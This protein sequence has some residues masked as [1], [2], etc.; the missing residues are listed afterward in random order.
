MDEAEYVA[1]LVALQDKRWKQILRV[2]RP[3]QMNILWHCTGPTLDVGCGIGR[4]LKVLPQGSVGVDTN[5][6][7]VAE[8]Q[9]RGMTAVVAEEFQSDPAQSQG[10]FAAV[11]F[12]HVLEH[13]SRDEAVRLVSDYRRFVKPGGT[14]VVVCPQEVGYASDETHT[15]FV[16]FEAAQQILNSAGVKVSRQYSFPFPRP[17]GRQFIYN[18]FITVGRLPN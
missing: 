15:E 5:R 8:A 9:R 11:L 17:L 1:R 7:A 13:V 12:S 3:Y 10:R 6:F 2:Q 4:N 18:E 14:V 16:D